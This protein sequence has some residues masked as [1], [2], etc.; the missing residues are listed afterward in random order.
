MKKSSACFDAK[1]ENSGFVK[2][3]G[4]FFQIVKLSHNVLNLRMIAYSQLR[5]QLIYKII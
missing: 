1:S 5:K 2:T 4:R 3:E